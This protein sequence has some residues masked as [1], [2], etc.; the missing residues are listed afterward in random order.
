MTDF[1]NR[2]PSISVIDAIILAFNHMITVLFRP[3]KP[4]KW[5]KFGLVA[6]LAALGTS[7]GNSFNFNIPGDTGKKFAELEPF[8]NQAYQWV[9]ANLTL[10]IIVGI[11][12]ILLITIIWA[13]LIYFGSR[14]SFVFLDGVI[15]KDVRIKQAYKENK[16]LGWSYFLW[17]II[18]TPNALLA[19][20]LIIGIPTTILI[21]AGVDKGF[22]LGII[23]GLV[24]AGLVFIGLLIILAIIGVFTV[25]FI[26]PIMY[27]RKIRILQAWKIFWS[28]LRTN[29]LQFFLY[30]L[31]KMGLSLASLLV[32][33]LSMCVVC[34]VAIPPAAIL[35][36]LVVLSIQYPLVWIAVALAF[37]PLIVGLG[38]LT[39][40]VVLP[41]TVFFRTYPI[42]FLE[43]FAEEFV[44]ISKYQRP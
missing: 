29:K 32:M 15:K 30:I 13:V 26:V 36:G 44:C 41:V 34:C 38:I 11:A 28:I 25:D 42:V 10:I 17:R 27:L 37:I 9:L 22:S 3:F 6:F 33:C 24:G 19:I 8:F 2:Q 14:F 39:Q 31:L 5:L 12:V 43:G 16:T 35:V 18:F 23:L 7:Q 1:T 4:V 21:L 40:T 20:L